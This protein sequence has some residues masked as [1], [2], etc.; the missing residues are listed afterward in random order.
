MVKVPIGKL[1]LPESSATCNSQGGLL[2]FPF[3]FLLLPS[4]LLTFLPRDAVHSFLLALSM[5]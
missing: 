3:Q 5:P 2:S 1:G 4:N